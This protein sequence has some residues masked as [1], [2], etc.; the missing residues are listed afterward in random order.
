MS[1]V[2][3]V[4]SMVASACLTLAAVHMLVWFRRREVWAH[5]LFALSAVGTALLAACELWVMRAE[6]PAQF[7]V[8]VRWGH[9]AFWVLMISLVG[10]VRVYMRAG[11]PW[12]AWTVCGVRTLSLILNF[13]FSPNLNYREITALRQVRFLGESVSVAEGLP[14]PWM[15]VGQASLFLLL[16]FVVDATFTVRRRG[17]RRSA[18]VLSS[19]IVFFVVMSSGQFVLTLWGIIPVPLTP[20]LFYLGIVAAMSF[21]LSQDVL[22]AARLSDDLGESE[23]RMTLAAEAAE[24]GVW[25]WKVPINRVWGSER[26]RCLFGFGPDAAVTFEMVIQ[27]IHPDDREI[28]EREVRRVLADGGDYAVEYRVILPDGTQKWIAFRGRMYPGAQGKPARMLGAAIDVTRR[29]QAEQ[30]IVQQRNELVHVTRVSTMGQLASSL[31]HELNQPLGAILRNAEAAEL[32]LQDP[33]PDLDELRAI[34]ADIR[35]DDQRAGEVIDRMRALMKQR[36]P[37]RRR[38]DFSLLAGDVVTLV[39]QDAEM[40]LMRLVLE[41]DPALPPVYG[42]RVQLQQVLLNL[43][44]NAMDALDDNP[45]A[46]RLVTARTRHV[47]ATIEVTVSDTGHGLS[48]DNL[49]LVFKPFFSSKPNGLGMGLAISRGI[50]EAHGGRLWAENNEAGG[51]TFAFTL[52]AAKDSGGEGRGARE[53]VA[54]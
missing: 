17:D 7:G 54:R 34:L 4:W 29:K 49:L 31:A 46:R 16:V 10:F 27:R 35:K 25:M 2:T 22:R 11:R 43:L 36:Q 50:I 47:G 6:T 51:A 32:F 5:A 13:V 21:E 15:L 33:A 12:L 45:P 41:T 37:E 23:E 20:S 52:P 8:A 18:L 14:N 3:I 38:L 26:W 1:W 40:R 24:F 39:R 30:E 48:A 19:T 42:D 53:E 9:V 28:V 44:L